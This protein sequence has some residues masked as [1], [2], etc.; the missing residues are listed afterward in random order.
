MVKVISQE[1]FDAVVKENMEDL[2]MDKVE[3]IKEAKEQ[4]QAQGVDLANIVFSGD[5]DQKEQEQQHAVL[6]ALEK[7]RVA[8]NVGDSADVLRSRLAEGLAER[9][10]ATKAGAYEHLVKRF[11]ETEDDAKRA[12][13]MSALQALLDGNPD[14][15]ETEGFKVQY[16]Q[17]RI[18][19]S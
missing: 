15:L 1:T 12:S 8:D 18:T 4:F 16:I 2:G 3:A 14:P 5:N 9:V 7:L 19:Q 11:L 10:L 17:G 6:L 13:L